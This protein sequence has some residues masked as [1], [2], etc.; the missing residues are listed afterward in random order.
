[1]HDDCFKHLGHDLALAAIQDIQFL[2]GKFHFVGIFRI[3]LLELLGWVRRGI[4]FI[5]FLLE[6]QGGVLWA[7][8]ILA[9]M[10]TILAQLSLNV[11]GNGS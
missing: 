8:L 11:T 6:G 5:S 10:I 4:G 3:M 2:P 7:L 9:L 1:M